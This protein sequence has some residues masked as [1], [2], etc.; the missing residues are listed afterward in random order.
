MSR[1]NIYPPRLADRFL[2]WFCSDE[3]LETLQGDLYELYEKRRERRGKLLADIY[4]AFDV[5]S[6]LR[7]FAFE[8][9][10]S[11][12]NYT[13]MLRHTFLISFRSF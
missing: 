8:K 12:S 13:G 10:R 4:Y 9:K 11:N 3:V 6:A 2:Q 1:K 5:L 7:P